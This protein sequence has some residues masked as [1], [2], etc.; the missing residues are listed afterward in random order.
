MKN[1][2]IILLFGG[3]TLGTLVKGC[4]KSTKENKNNTDNNKHQQTEKSN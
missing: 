3:L 1:T 2:L 4:G